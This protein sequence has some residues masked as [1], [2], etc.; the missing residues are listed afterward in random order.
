MTEQPMS[1]AQRFLLRPEDFNLP[2]GVSPVVDRHG[3]V[4]AFLNAA[5]HPLEYQNNERLFAL[6]AER[7]D[8]INEFEAHGLINLKDLQNL[9][10]E[11]G[12][13]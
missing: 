9:H 8:L 1:L 6:F 12:G 7:W 13:E 5:G 4:L 10:T 3:F 2:E 11:K